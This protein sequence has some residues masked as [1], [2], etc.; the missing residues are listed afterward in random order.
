[1]SHCVRYKAEIEPDAAWAERYARMQPIF[2]TLYERSR[3]LYDELDELAR[4]VVPLT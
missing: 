3:P 4:Y 2:D 1:V